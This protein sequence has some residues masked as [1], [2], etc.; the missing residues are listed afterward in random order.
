[1]LK[2]Y[3]SRLIII[4]KV[5]MDIENR[6]RPKKAFGLIPLKRFYEGQLKYTS[7]FYAINA[8]LALQ[9]LGLIS[10]VMYSFEHINNDNLLHTMGMILTISL[11]IVKTV[12]IYFLF[13][14]LKD[15]NIKESYKSHF[16]FHKL[17]I[18]LSLVNIIFTILLRY[19]GTQ[20][21]QASMGLF[22]MM[23]GLGISLW[24]L[25]HTRS[26]F[27]A[28]GIYIWKKISQKDM[29]H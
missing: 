17:F 29:L 20:S 3:E 26:L 12:I 6:D 16:I 28:F 8:I 21:S 9:V 7:V 22:E 25:Y 4:R 24:M 23:F 5:L 2:Y 18:P 1:M 14:A 15:K 10:S 19:I 27:D 13:V 11:S